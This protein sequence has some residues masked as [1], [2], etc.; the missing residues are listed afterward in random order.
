[1]KKILVVGATS[2]I[3][4]A[5]ARIWASRGAEL[6]LVARN[7]NKLQ[8]NAADLQTRGASKVYTYQL[9]A[10]QID[11]HQAMLEHCLEQLGQIDIALIAYGSL[12]DQQS[13]QHDTFTAV[14]EFTLNATSVISIANIL[15]IQFERQR[16]GSLAVISSVA[17]DRGRPSNYLY[18]SAKGAVSIFCAGLH[19]RLHKKGVQVLTIKPGFVDTPMT[20]GLELPAALLSTPEKVATQIVCAIGTSKAVLYTP[21]IWRWI[22]LVIRSIPVFVF[23]RLNL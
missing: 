9:D 4:H 2:A 7:T 16:C 21:G 13:C 11:Q 15:A 14:Q 5:C 20:A 10:V 3:A 6:F 1:M 23:R 17:G 22:M 8:A 12:P 19:A 18:G